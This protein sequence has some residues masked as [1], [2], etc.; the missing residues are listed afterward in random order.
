MDTNWLLARTYVAHRRIG[1]GSWLQEAHDEIGALLDAALKGRKVAELSNE[2]VLDAFRPAPVV[3][4]PVSKQY[5]K[6]KSKDE[7]EGS[8]G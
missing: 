3:S 4:T 1:V 6:F 5:S 8:N 7:D 2:E